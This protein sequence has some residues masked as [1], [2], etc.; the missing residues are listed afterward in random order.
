MNTRYLKYEINNSE[1]ILYILCE[2]N[3]IHVINCEKYIFL[4]QCTKIIEE[5]N[6]KWISS[7]RFLKL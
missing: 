3:A 6:D 2:N 7:K 4:S 5:N 1:Y